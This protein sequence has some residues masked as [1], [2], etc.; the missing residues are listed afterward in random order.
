MGNH[1]L[2]PLVKWLCILCTLEPDFL[3]IDAAGPC[4]SFIGVLE[5]DMLI[6]WQG[7]ND[8]PSVCLKG[9]WV[10]STFRD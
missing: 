5:R 3:R 6:A 10:N 7:Y 1:F 8:G 9:P 4:R 2:L